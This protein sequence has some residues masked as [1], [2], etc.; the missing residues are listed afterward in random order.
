MSKIFVIVGKTASGKTTLV[1]KLQRLLPEK[2]KV[3]VAYTTREKR[4]KEKHG[5]DYNFIDTMKMKGLIATGSVDCVRTY[6]NA[7]GEELI[8]GLPSLKNDD[9]SSK[10]VITDVEGLKELQV[11]YAGDVI[12]FFINRSIEDRYNNLLKRGDKPNEIWRRI[13]AD[14]KDFEGVEFLVDYIFNNNFKKGIIDTINRILKM[15]GEVA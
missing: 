3:V 7:D 14:E 6:V 1:K 4:P 8:Y 2:V 13:E 12:S 10:I 11:K 5:I 15:Y 9:G